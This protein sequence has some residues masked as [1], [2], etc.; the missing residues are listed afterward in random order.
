MTIAVTARSIVVG[1]RA[2]DLLRHGA[3]DL[4]SAGE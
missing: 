3:G 1:N 2:D 4:A